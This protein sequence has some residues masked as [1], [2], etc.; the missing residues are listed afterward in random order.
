MSRDHRPSAGRGHESAPYRLPAPP[1]EK[2]GPYSF[3]QD[4]SGQKLTQDTLLL[5]EFILPL[6][7]NDIVADLGSGTGPL[8]LI[9]AS[10]SPVK[11][12]VC[13]EAQKTLCDIARRNVIAN[14]LTPRVEVVEKDFRELTEV[15]PEGSFS[16]V[17]SNPPYMKLGSGRISPVKERAISRSEVL[18]GLEDLVQASRHLCGAYGRI[19]YVF[20][21]RRLEEM[22]KEIERAGLR[23][24][25]LRPVYTHRDRA[26]KLF[27][28]EA[29]YRGSLKMEEPLY[30][31][32]C[33]EMALGPGVC[34]KGTG[35]VFF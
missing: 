22:C 15:Y 12:I 18:G 6:E 2:I 30:L 9:L 26:A 7:K 10:R 24:R 31:T 29:G 8:A 34:L 27:V 35:P 20:P 17:A 32:G 33:R 23:K 21:V 13:V 4:D 28:I 19:S 1:V 5:A 14:G 3:I 11:R 16:V 25:R